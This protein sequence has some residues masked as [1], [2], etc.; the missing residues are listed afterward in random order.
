MTIELYK[1][2]ILDSPTLARSYTNNSKR[3]VDKMRKRWINDLKNLKGDYY[4]EVSD[5]PDSNAIDWFDSK[6]I[7]EK[8]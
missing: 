2:H 4:I 5:I 6:I 1:V 3:L 8:I 7:K